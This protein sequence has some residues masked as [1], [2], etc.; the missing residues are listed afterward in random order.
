[1]RRSCGLLGLCALACMHVC[2]SSSFACLHVCVSLRSRFLSCLHI[3]LVTTPVM[4]TLAQTCTNTSYTGEEVRCP[5]HGLQAQQR[6]CAGVFGR[7]PSS[8]ASSHCCALCWAAV[9]S[10]T[11]GSSICGSFLPCVVGSC[12]RAALL[13]CVIGGR[14]S[15]TSMQR[16]P[17]VVVKRPASRRGQEAGVKTQLVDRPCVRLAT[18][19]CQVY[20]ENHRLRLAPHHHQRVRLQK[21]G[22]CRRGHYARALDH[23]E[24]QG[25]RRVLPHLAVR[26]Q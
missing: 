11:P 2:V 3:C 25:V 22:Q 7:R 16:R 6:R 5:R 26:L 15:N 12:H 14:I 23:R 9:R 18:D 19:C 4:P 17:D 13:L 1:M 21:W 24:K 10:A 8:T 20:V